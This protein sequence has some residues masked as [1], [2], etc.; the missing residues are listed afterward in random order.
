MNRSLKEKLT[1]YLS[2]VALG[3]AAVWLCISSRWTD[4]LSLAEKYCILCDAFSVPGVLI[5][6]VAV[7][8][9]MNNLGALDG[10]AYVLG[11]I[12]RMFAPGAFGEPEHYLDYVEARREKR[13]KGYGF[14]YVVGLVFLGISIVFLMLYLSAEG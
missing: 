14:L 5:F 1:K 13:V 2:T 10:I 6:S 12:P 11:Y 7:M 4:S 9:S 8:F 3:I